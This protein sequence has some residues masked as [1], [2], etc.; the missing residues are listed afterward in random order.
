VDVVAAAGLQRVRAARARRNHFRIRVRRQ[1]PSSRC[2]HWRS[3]LAVLAPLAQGA[4]PNHKRGIAPYGD[5]V[6]WARRRA[7]DRG[8]RENREARQDTEIA[9]FTRRESVS[10]GR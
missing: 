7:R 5:N 2:A 1:A 8:R 4:A 10:A 3:A 6:Y 9:D